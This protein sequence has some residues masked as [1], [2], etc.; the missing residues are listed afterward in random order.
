R[1]SRDAL[2][3]F[4]S[5]EADRP[6][7]AAQ[8]AE[9]TL[10]PESAHDLEEVPEVERVIDERRRACFVDAHVRLEPIEEHD[11]PAK[12]AKAEQI[13]EEHPGMPS[14]ARFLCERS[15]DDDGLHVR[16]PERRNPDLI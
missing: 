15:G 11:V 1:R 10:E 14:A 4:R 16:A 13:L 12:L 8:E 5:A 9:A 3:D 6:L 2:Q 7:P